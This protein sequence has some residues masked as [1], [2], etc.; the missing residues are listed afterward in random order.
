M[1]EKTKSKGSTFELYVDRL[2]TEWK[3]HG[4]III[5]VDYDDTIFPWKFRSQEQCDEVISLLI[6]AKATGAYIA[7]FTCSDN[8]RH[9]EIDAYCASKGLA[10]DSI[11]R[12]PIELPY[13]KEGKIYYNI[14]LCDRSGLSETCSILSD[15]LYKYRGYRQSQEIPKL[16]DIA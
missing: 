13:G 1:E 5:A 8:S 10:I 4:K 6:Q 3:Q 14:N 16:G 15:A 7:I 9:K 11:N 12:N 2:L